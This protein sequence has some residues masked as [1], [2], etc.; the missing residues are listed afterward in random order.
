VKKVKVKRTLR[1][2]QGEASKKPASNHE[3]NKKNVNASEPLMKGDE[4]DKES[5]NENRRL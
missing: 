2:S 3:G 5:E 4:E 1:E